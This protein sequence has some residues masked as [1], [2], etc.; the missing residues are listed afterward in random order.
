MRRVVPCWISRRRWRKEIIVHPEEN[1]RA[2]CD[3]GTDA[4]RNLVST[5]GFEVGNMEQA[6]AQSA[7][8]LERTYDT[9]ANSQ[10]MMEPF[11][12]YTCFDKYGRLTVVSSTQVPFHVRRIL[13]SALEMPEGEIRVIKPRIGGGFGAKQSVVS[14]LFRLW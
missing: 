4:Q 14:E 13:P 1:F 6:L 12:T 7:V 3:V 9:K 5:E 8:V 10:A 11:C 2:L